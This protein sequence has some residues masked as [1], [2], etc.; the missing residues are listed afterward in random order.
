MPISYEAREGLAAA[1]LVSRN[2]TLSASLQARSQ[3]RRALRSHSFDALFFHTQVTALFAHRL[4]LTI[5]TVVSM[6]ATPINFDTIGE[7]YAHAPS[8]IRQVESLKNTLT[9]R[10]FDRARRLVVWHEWGKKSLVEDYGA[11]AEKVAV[12]A[13]GVDL[14]RWNFPRTV[15]ADSS[16]VRLLFVG[17]DFQ[18]KGGEVLLAAMQRGLSRCELDIVTRDQVET[19]GMPNVRVHR[20]VQPNAPELMEL[21][22]RADVFVFPTFAD[23]LPLAIMEAMASSLPVVTT[24]VGAIGEQ[25]E[26]GT[27]GFLVPPGDVGALVATTTRLVANPELRFRM[28][29]AGRRAAD[30]L[31][32]GSK[33]YAR[34]L[35]IMKICADQAAGRHAWR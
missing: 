24:K 32:N 19:P 29:A 8:A 10:G 11:P 5:P 20:G 18:R 33:N 21:Y 22:S 35:A 34:I 26:D 16:P 4:M 23:V 13:P 14:D 27:T 30:R 25:I 2:W 9:R 15:S 12:I 6:D 28:G 1:P 31:F 17:G 7:P 3:V